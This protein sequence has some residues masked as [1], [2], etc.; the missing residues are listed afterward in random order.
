MAVHCH[1]FVIESCCLGL[2]TCRGHRTL[3][4]SWGGQ[5]GPAAAAASQTEILWREFFSDPSQW[6]DCRPEKVNVRYQDFKHKKTGDALGVSDNRS[7][8]WV[9]AEL[10]AMAPGTVP[11]DTF[12]WNRKL[13]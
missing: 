2:L 10:A 7:P 11:L 12:S 13:S 4:S 1:R 5:D 3:A 8:P 6:W 9:V